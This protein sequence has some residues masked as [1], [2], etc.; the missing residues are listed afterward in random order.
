MAVAQF[1]VLG[2]LFDGFHAIGVAV[3]GGKGLVF[4]EVEVEKVV[5]GLGATKLD[6]FSGHQL[7]VAVVEAAQGEP[8]LGVARRNA[9]GF[10]AQNGV[11]DDEGRQWLH[12]F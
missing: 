2:G 3:G 10:L 4:G 7:Q 12:L 8:N 1:E 9:E 5:F 11:R 6:D